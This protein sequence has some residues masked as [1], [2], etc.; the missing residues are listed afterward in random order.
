MENNDKQFAALKTSKI[1]GIGERFKYLEEAVTILFIFGM[2]VTLLIIYKDK[3]TD[4][5]F[6]HVFTLLSGLVMSVAHG[7]LERSKLKK[8]N[9]SLKQVEEKGGEE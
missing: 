4:T 5:I 6:I 1:K 8:F 2:F 3:I 9:E 7:V